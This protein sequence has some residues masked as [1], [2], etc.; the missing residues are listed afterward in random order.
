MSWR[1]AEVRIGSREIILELFKESPPIDL[2]R[3]FSVELS[4]RLLINAHPT[5]KFSLTL[6]DKNILFIEVSD[7]R[8]KSLD[9]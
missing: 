1:L 7:S 3:L 9:P 6:F 5:F 2:Y 4:R 8:I